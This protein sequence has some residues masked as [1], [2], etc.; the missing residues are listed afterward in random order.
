VGFVLTNPG[1]FLVN[2]RSLDVDF[3]RGFP[4]LPT[5][6]ARERRLGASLCEQTANRPTPSLQATHSQ[7]EPMAL[8]DLR[9]D[10]AVLAAKLP[11]PSVIDETSAIQGTFTDCSSVVT[12]DAG[13][14]HSSDAT[15][16]AR[17]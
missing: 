6:D 15:A 8:V 4:E 7:P 14:Q 12:F 11:V 17:H 16:T 5:A 9:E 10:I 3:N 13:C 2:E 1:A